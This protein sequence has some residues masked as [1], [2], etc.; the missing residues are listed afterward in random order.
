MDGHWVWGG[1]VVRGED[2]RYHMFASRWPRRLP[3]FDGYRTRSEVVRAVADAPGGPYAFR[4]VVL[5]AR[6]PEHW[7][8]RMTHNPTIHRCGGIY[9]L[10]Y[11]GSTYAGPQPSARELRPGLTSAPDESYANIRIGL[12]TAHSV[13]GPWRRSPEPVLCPRPGKWDG[14]VV[15]NPAP[16]VLEDR[17]ILLLY[18]SNTPDGLR[19]GAAVADGPDGPFERISDGPVLRLEGRGHVEDPCVWRAGDHFEL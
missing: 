1:S 9:L 3:F 4:E 5:P 14:F 11:I 6:G 16:C 15:T 10:F 7:D 8:G 18:R 2:G 13:F 17:R 12:A 19:I